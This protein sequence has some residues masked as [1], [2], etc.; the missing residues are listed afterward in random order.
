MVAT[1]H[2]VVVVLHSWLFNHAAWGFLRSCRSVLG[3]PTELLRGLNYHVLTLLYAVLNS[4]KLTWLCRTHLRNRGSSL[5]YLLVLLLLVLHLLA[6][7]TFSLPLWSGFRCVVKI[8]SILWSWVI[9][10]HRLWTFLL[11]YICTT[12][13]ICVKSLL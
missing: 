5:A 6:I 8:A 9:H 2:L 11:S 12:W 7:S 10:L 13:E 1:S 3:V 4:D